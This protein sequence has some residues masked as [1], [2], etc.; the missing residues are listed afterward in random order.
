M[1]G[2]PGKEHGSNKSPPTRRV[3]ERSK[4][5]T[6]CLTTSQNPRWHP[7]WLRHQEGLWVRWLAKDNPETN[8]I[9][10]KPETASHVS[11]LFFWVPLPS[12]SP[13]GCPFPIKSLALP[14]H[15]SPWTIYFQVLGTPHLRPLTCGCTL[16]CF[17]ILAAVN[18]VVTQSSSRLWLLWPH[19]LQHARLPCP[20]L[21]SG[22]CS[23][24]CRLSQWCHPAIAAAPIYTP[25]NTA[26][27]F[28]FLYILLLFIVFLMIA[29]LTCLRW[30]FIVLICIFLIIGD[31]EHLSV[32]LLAI[33]VLSTKKIYLDLLS[34][35]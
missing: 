14:A 31:V 33:C 6:T 26:Q 25:T 16:G 32:C 20:S 11:E 24:S 21:S 19:G 4:G 13:S 15:V 17:H 22:V 30:Y 7:S 34:I 1:T 12:C 10:V 9:T 28:P 3:R 35:F 18:V 2:G 27:S 5:D 23:N 8:P 29:I